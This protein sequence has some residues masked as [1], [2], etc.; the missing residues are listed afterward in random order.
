MRMA[1][2]ESSNYAKDSLDR[3][4]TRELNIYVIFGRHSSTLV[5]IHI[6]CLPTRRHS[7]SCTAQL[8][9]CIRISL[10]TSACQPA[11]FNDDTPFR[12]SFYKTSILQPDTER[13][14]PVHKYGPSRASSKDL[15]SQHGNEVFSA[16]ALAHI[17]CITQVC[18][19]TPKH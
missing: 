10:G 7:L 1:L 2:G 16:I 17:H 4:V 18:S 15:R 14:L 8:N 12:Q 3:S 6:V 11:V 9:R 19:K 5:S 13:P